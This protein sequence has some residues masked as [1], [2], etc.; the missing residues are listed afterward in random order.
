M[1]DLQT[2]QQVS[3]ELS[4]FFR[5]FLLCLLLFRRNIRSFPLFT[6]YLLI[7]LSK[8]LLL[9]F[10]YKIW[11]FSSPISY[12]IAW[13]SEAIVICA[14]AL[15]VA[16]LCRLLLVGCRGIWSLAWRVLLTCAALVLLYSFFVSAHSWDL[17]LLGASRALELTI[18]AVI[19]VL[20]VFLR[21]YQVVSEPSVR[22]LALGFCVYSCI[23]VLNYTILQRWLEA[24]AP[25]W[26]ALGVFAYLACLLVW[27]WALR[28]SIPRPVLSPM[29][30]PSSVYR[31]LSPE[32]NS[33]LHALNEQLS[34]FWR[35]EAPRP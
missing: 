18:A 25:L 3:W 12:G 20:F 10:A 21:H 17:A 22:S 24:Y 32:I 19:V 15:A 4:I 23:A 5:A 7:N 14:R 16:E 9:H 33:R 1:L 11:G 35:I 26:S 27:T 28:K 13:G 29:L 2:A 8:A 34:Q 30:L 6:A 31:Q